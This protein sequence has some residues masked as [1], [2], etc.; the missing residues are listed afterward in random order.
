MCNTF[1]YI[2]AKGEKEVLIVIKISSCFCLVFDQIE[3]KIVCSMD[4]PLNCRDET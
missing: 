2:L 1:S 4:G 3:Y